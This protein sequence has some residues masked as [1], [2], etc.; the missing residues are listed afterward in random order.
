MRGDT[1]ELEFFQNNPDK[2]SIE[3][4]TLAR[5]VRQR[6]LARSQRETLLLEVE[7]LHQAIN[8]LRELWPNW[9]QL[10]DGFT[11]DPDWNNE[12]DKE[13]RQSMIEWGRKWL[14]APEVTK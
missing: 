6:D 10:V 13:T 4:L 3:A 9:R 12:W 8:E 7:K 1:D 11:Q 5:C 2:H 14:V